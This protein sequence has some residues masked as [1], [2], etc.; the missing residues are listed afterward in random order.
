MIDSGYKYR[1]TA[2]TQHSDNRL[3]LLSYNIQVGIGSHSYKD[4][5]M[6]SWRHILPDSKRQIHLANIA[7]WMADF[8]IVA[9]QE[10]DAG[11][12]RTQFVNQVAFLAQ[13]GGFPHWHHQQNRHLGKFAAHSNGLLTKHPVE[14]I[15]HHKLPGRIAGR[16][17]LQA[18]FGKGEHQLLVL[19][20]HLALSPQARKKQLTYICELLA[21]YPYYVIMGDMNCDHKQAAKEFN[22]SGLDVTVGNNIQPTFPRWNPKHHY[23]QIWVSSNLRIVDCQVMELGVSD[24]LPIMMEIEIPDKLQSI[25]TI[26]EYYLN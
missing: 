4:Y 22:K 2:P 19:S 8:D 17:A 11:S 15:V 13:K 23:D 1:P 26:P 12:L 16:G 21:A 14:H 6:Q 3:K 24:H 7:Q 9:L 25:K 18:N 20:L 5:V 10:V